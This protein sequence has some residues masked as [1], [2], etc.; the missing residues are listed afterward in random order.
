MLNQI[1]HSEYH[2]VFQ[3]YSFVM[4]DIRAE[5]VRRTPHPA[6]GDYLNDYLIETSPSAASV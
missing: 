2:I 5:N 1:F 3:L 4:I 6:S